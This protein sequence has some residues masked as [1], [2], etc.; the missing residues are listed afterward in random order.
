ML[1]GAARAAAGVSDWARSERR[2][3]ELIDLFFGDLF[4]TQQKKVVAEWRRVREKA[5]GAGPAGQGIP[6]V[7]WEHLT[8]RDGLP[9]ARVVAIK[10]DAESV[11]FACAPAQKSNAGGGIA[12][13]EK[14]SKKVRSYPLACEVRDIACSETAVWVG[15]DAGLHRLDRAH[16]R[17][18]VYRVKDGLPH[19]AVT[20]LQLEGD[21]LWIGLGTKGG[22]EYSRGALAL[23]DTSKETFAWFASSTNSAGKNTAPP[24]QAVKSLAVSTAEVWVAVSGTGLFRYDRKDNDWSFANSPADPRNCLSCLDLRGNR[25]WIGHYC[26]SSDYRGG[27]ACLDIGRNVWSVLRFADGLLANDVQALC[28]GRKYIWFGAAFPPE[29]AGVTRYDPRNQ[30]FQG[31][32]T[33]D[34]LLHNE[35]ISIIEDQDDVW[36][37][38]EAGASCLRGGAAVAP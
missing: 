5:G 13:L 24:C 6:A 18:K 16:G 21:R 22:G 3:R 17:W 15:T 8:V 33:A 11:W 27:A 26:F 37:G 19:D 38:T 36:F 12:C 28:A 35:V 30:T 32:T 34:G 23:M 29:L 10:A 9:A 14:R 2:Y 4:D 1:E 7:N 31:I 20:C 25:L